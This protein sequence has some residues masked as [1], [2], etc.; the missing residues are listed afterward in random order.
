MNQNLEQ[1]VRHVGGCHLYGIHGEWGEG[2]GG[3]THLEQFNTHLD[4][5]VPIY[6]K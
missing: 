1:P 5:S 3:G 4:Q 6:T 2:G